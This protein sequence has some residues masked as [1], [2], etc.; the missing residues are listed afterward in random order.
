MQNPFL[1][2]AG[3]GGMKMP[4]GMGNIT[5]ENIQQAFQEH[6][7]FDIPKSTKIVA[8]QIC[9]DKQELIDMILKKKKHHNLIML[10][11]NA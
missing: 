6:V 4:Q 11:E 8:V 9:K 3:M 7:Q 2:M 1:N 5:N 10:D